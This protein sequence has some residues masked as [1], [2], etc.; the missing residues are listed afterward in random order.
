MFKFWWKLLILQLVITVFEVYE[1][2]CQP[3]YVQ[4]KI[5]TQKK[6]REG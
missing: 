1:N 5:Q 2:L 3:L 4:N 6:E